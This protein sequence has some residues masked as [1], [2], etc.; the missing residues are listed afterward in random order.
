MRQDALYFTSA[1]SEKTT[2]AVASAGKKLL[3]RSHCDSIIIIILK[4]LSHVVN[5]SIKK[6]QQTV[7]VPQMSIDLFTAASLWNTAAEI[8]EHSPSNACVC[9]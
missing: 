9:T 6:K 4:F 3:A 8:C 5:I 1:Y 7:Q 2:D